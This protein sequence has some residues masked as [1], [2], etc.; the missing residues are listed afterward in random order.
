MVHKVVVA[1]VSINADIEFPRIGAA[2]VLVRKFIFDVFGPVIHIVLNFR[3]IDVAIRNNA[4]ESVP[5]EVRLPFRLNVGSPLWW[6]IAGY[7]TI[8]DV[9]GEKL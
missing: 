6:Q 8:N 7:T 1:V 4:Q 5:H 9:N 3:I 2:H